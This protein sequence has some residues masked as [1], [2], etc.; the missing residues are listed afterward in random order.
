MPQKNIIN[1]V[2]FFY[3]PYSLGWTRS[4]NSLSRNIRWFF[5]YSINRCWPLDLIFPGTN[6][7]CCRKCACAHDNGDYIVWQEQNT[8]YH[9]WYF[10]SECERK[11][12]NGRKKESDR[13]RVYLDSPAFKLRYSDSCSDTYMSRVYKRYCHEHFGFMNTV[14]VARYVSNNIWRSAAICM[15]SVCSISQTSRSF[16]SSPSVLKKKLAHP[17]IVYGAITVALSVALE[18]T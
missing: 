6:I 13:K 15:F 17:L 8:I 18:S 4:S 3:A 5:N 12:T 11:M 1:K 14:I 16:F 2:F 9:V 10:V 7:R